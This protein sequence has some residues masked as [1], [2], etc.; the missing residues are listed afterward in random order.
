MIQDIRPGAGFVWVKD[1]TRVHVIRM[2]TVIECSYR[3][4]FTP[5]VGGNYEL[6]VRLKGDHS[7]DPGLLMYFKTPEDRKDAIMLLTTD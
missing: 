6:F 3:D 5:P 7:E 2:G 1:A 4:P